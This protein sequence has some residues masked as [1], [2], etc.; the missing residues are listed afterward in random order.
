MSRILTRKSFEGSCPKIVQ[1]DP[2]GSEAGLSGLKKNLKNHL[3]DQKTDP[4][5]FNVSF[6]TFFEI[7]GTLWETHIS[8]L[9]SEGG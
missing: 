4:Q 3:K 2:N 8:Q 1:N 7:S 6:F 9:H 5:F